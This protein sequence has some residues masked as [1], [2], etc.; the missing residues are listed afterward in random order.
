L[1]GR[2]RTFFDLGGK[3]FTRHF[4]TTYPSYPPSKKDKGE[5]GGSPDFA[6]FFFPAFKEGQRGYVQSSKRDIYKELKGKSGI[7]LFINKITNNLYVGSSVTLSKRM[8][9]H[10]FHGNSNKDTRVVLYRAMRKY[11]LENFSLAILV[12]LRGLCGPV[13]PYSRSE[14]VRGQT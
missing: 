12:P 7:Y 3:R 2:N 8:A 4:G 13:F 1:S 10:F 5:K 9:A 14:W 6:M 11:K